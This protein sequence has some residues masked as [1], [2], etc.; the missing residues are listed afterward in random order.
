[1]ESSVK[2]SLLLVLLVWSL[3]VT[4]AITPGQKRTTPPAAPRSTA[5][6]PARAKSVPLAEA[7][8]FVNKTLS[9]G[10]EIVVFEDHSVPL[11]TVELAI[12][13]GSFTE[14]PELNGLSHLYEHMFFKANRAMK[15]GADY[16]QNIDQLGISYNGTTREEESE[17]F[18]T[19]T[20]PNFPVAMRFIRDSARYPAFDQKDFDQERQVV[21]GEIDR[22]QSNPYGV[23]GIELNRR[24]FY[25]YPT[26]K[27]PLG[28]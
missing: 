6:A 17:Y 3:L 19:T 16:M 1:M 28:T 21:I 15:E 27:N 2:R 8:P 24:L 9:N 22:Q 11:V 18:M 26:R 23:L 4:P 14:T 7:V 20:T 10:L 12:R 25:Q 5:A 13:N